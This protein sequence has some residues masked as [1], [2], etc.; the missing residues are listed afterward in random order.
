MRLLETTDDR[1]FLKFSG[2]PSHRWCN[3]ETPRNNGEVNHTRKFHLKFRNHVPW[4]NF[5]AQQLVSD[6]DFR[7][8]TLFS[9]SSNPNNMIFPM[10]CTYCPMYFV[11]FSHPAQD[12]INCSPL[13]GFH[14]TQ[15]VAETEFSFIAITSQ[16]LRRIRISKRKS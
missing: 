7:G 10:R 11:F 15:S 12:F 13:T 2:H 1:H 9:L 16:H 4:R 8:K 5:F 14:L 6:S 3:L